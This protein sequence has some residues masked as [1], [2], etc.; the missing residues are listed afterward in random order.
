MV[1]EPKKLQRNSNTPQNNSNK[2]LKLDSELSKSRKQIYAENY[3]KNKER[4]KQQRRER[5]Q[6]QKAQ[7]E[8]S[9]REQQ[10]KYYGVE[11]IKILMS[12]KEYTELNS[13]KHKL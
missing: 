3:Q 9:T 4:K 12:L 8:L 11:S 7:A 10:S 13:I 6:Q 5:Y 2:G 1:K